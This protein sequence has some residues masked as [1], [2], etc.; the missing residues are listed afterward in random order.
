MLWQV[1]HKS[2]SFYKDEDHW[3]MMISSPCTH[4][5]KDG[6]C[7]IYAQRPQICR[8]HS[9]DYCEFDAPAEDGWQMVFKNYE[10]LLAYCRKRFC[11]WGR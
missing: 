9:N 6:R 10:S 5:Q 1:S 3:Y 2:V 7:G 8:E 4:I 11:T